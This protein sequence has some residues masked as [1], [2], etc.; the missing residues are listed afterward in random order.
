MD[1]FL[2]FDFSGRD[3]LFV[4]RSFV[5]DTFRNVELGIVVEIKLVV[6]IVVVLLLGLENGLNVEEYMVNIGKSSFFCF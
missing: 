4:E 3:S 5:E 2:S 1:G 6:C